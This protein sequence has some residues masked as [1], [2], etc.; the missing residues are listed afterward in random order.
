M[1]VLQKVTLRGLK[2]NKVRT[3]TTLI[4]IMLSVALI[5]VVM[6]IESSYTAS[7]VINSIQYTGDYDFSFTGKFKESDY[8]ALTKDNRIRNIYTVRKLGTAKLEE[9]KNKYI[10]YIT[11]VGIN[12]Q[13]FSSGFNMELEQG[14]YPENDQEI[15]LSPEF[16]KQTGKNYKIGDKITLSFGQRVYSDPVS[17]EVNLPLESDYYFMGKDESFTEESQKTFTICGVLKNVTDAIGTNDFGASVNAYTIASFDGE[18]YVKESE[19]DVIY[20]RLHDNQEA[21]YAAV[22]A[23]LLN[24]DE[25]YLHRSIKNNLTESEGITLAQQM[26]K[27][28]SPLA[29]SFFNINTML[30][31]AK[32]IDK[33]PQDIAPALLASM[34]I[35]SVIVFASTMIIRSSFNMSITEKSRYFGMLSSI[36]ARPRQVSRSVFFEAL[37]LAVIGIPLGI[38][39]GIIIGFGFIGISNALLSEIISEIGQQTTAFSISVSGILISAAVGVFTIFLSALGAAVTASK[40]API[41]AIRS[42]NDIRI[43]GNKKKKKKYKAPRF[44][45][46][47]FGIGGVIAWKNMKRSKKQ[48]RTTVISI[49]IS[50]AIYITMST[51]VDYQLKSVNDLY[52]ASPYNM[53]IGLVTIDREKNEPMSRSETEALIE[54]ITSLSDV[55]ESVTTTGLGVN[56]M[57]I[58]ISDISKELVDNYDN[59]SSSVA[60]RE[61]NYYTSV[62][63]LAVDNQTFKKLMKQS[64]NDPDSNMSNAILYNR[65]T[66]SNSYK[67]ETKE[68][69]LIKFDKA[70]DFRFEYIHY[71]EQETAQA[72]E[73]S[74]EAVSNPSG[75][76][77]DTEAKADEWAF[78]DGYDSPMA[79][80]K[81]FNLKIVGSIYD[82]IY[83]EGNDYGNEDPIV[84]I[85]F[86]YL[87]DLE[88]QIPEVCET[89]L[90]NIAVKTDNPDELQNTLVEMSDNDKSLDLGIQN[91]TKMARMIKASMLSVELFMYGFIVIIALIGLTNIFN[92]ITTNV[93]LRRKEFAMLQ[94]IGMTKA[95]FN[96]MVSLES[97]LYALKSLILG[98][99]IG[100]LGSYLIFFIYDKTD[101]NHKT[102]YLFPGKAILISVLVVLVI[103]WGI[104]RFSIRKIRKQN[105]IETIRN[106]NI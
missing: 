50:V 52:S 84:F 37:V 80:Q 69:P 92:T 27:S 64:G 33:S 71:I 53:D 41:E 90:V 23:D 21:N 105:I 14:K 42:N 55:K 58:D 11:M 45:S 86:D 22:L 4:G 36:G 62:S 95:E 1:T 15:L 17:G 29:K 106:D 24:V 30:L 60:Q 87:K 2:L 81:F 97:L 61:G 51:F 70:K 98:L 66:L 7:R 5:T 38:V 59:Y 83:L 73:A 102:E 76:V 82:K 32:G 72:S 99:P 100:I 47:L 104:M 88:K 10:P 18:H 34:L 20:V 54:R 16:L 6:V 48:Y 78:G 74:S 93:R 91:Y 85:S 35:M 25:D 63:L 49:I 79:E 13:C 8:Q 12:K 26:S 44:V 89:N 3:I 103:I 68:I 77:S 57:H 101:F 96:R 39:M 43:S 19:P 56:G 65:I 31:D 40:I 28:D 94:S 75:T 67:H 46:M 9:P